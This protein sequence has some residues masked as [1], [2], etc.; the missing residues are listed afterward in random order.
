MGI[1]SLL[2][3]WQ[4][5]QPGRLTGGPKDILPPVLNTV[6]STPNL[7]TNFKKETI[8]LAFDE[9]LKLDKVFTEVVISPPLQY[10]PNIRLKGKSVLIDF[11][12]KEVLRPDATYTIN[13]GE[14]IRDYTEG[15][16]VKNMTYVFSTGNFIDSLSVK[17]TVRDAITGK[18]VDKAIVM[19]YENL[20]D[21]VVYRELPFYFGRTDKEGKFIINNVKA[22][23]FKVLALLEEFTSYKFD[24]PGES[25]GFLDEPILVSDTTRNDINVSIFQ[26]AV[27]NRIVK[28]DSS[29]Y[30]RLKFFFSDD[31][32]F[33]TIDSVAA[34]DGVEVYRENIADTLFL[35][36]NTT[37]TLPWPL[38]V[39]VDTLRDTIPV[40][41]LERDS[42]L[43]KAK[44]ETL[45]K[46]A[47]AATKI[48]P[49]K[50]LMIVFNEPLSRVD[51]SF[52]KLW[53]LEK[54]TTARDS[55]LPGDSLLM[56][57]LV[58]T[59]TL[60]QPDIILPDSLSEKEVPDRGMLI[61]SLNATVDSADRRNLSINMPWKAGATY[62]LQLMPGAVGSLRGLAYQDTFEQQYEPLSALDF[63]DITLNIRGIVPGQSYL[64]EVLF[65]NDNL[66]ESFSVANDTLVVRKI[67][68]VP[69]GKYQLRVTKDRNGN[70]RWDTGNYI[71]RE[72]PEVQRIKILEELRAG[73]EVEVEIDLEGLFS[74]KGS[75]PPKAEA[76]EEE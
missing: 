52:I 17:G 61:P 31:P 71:R 27:P 76:Q 42:F 47:A 16:I 50:P 9:F 13:F 49:L 30:G 11:D 2:T 57:A 44:L 1:L 35:W 63:G 66:V 34:P 6:A 12:D 22:G 32:V 37:D 3:L 33:A 26:E 64:L 14:A 20:S 45:K 8:T 41:S 21:S 56:D 5:A 54:D 15:N 75:L 69:S 25:I 38:Y 68:A 65:K 70:E 53:I 4:C 7:Q 36:H 18:A 62:S 29:R 23:R 67:V 60:K 55:L 59:D 10:N 24:N 19:L 58:L 28:I 73:W 74:R 48:N 40:R 39:T 43:K 72:Q 51:T 46:S